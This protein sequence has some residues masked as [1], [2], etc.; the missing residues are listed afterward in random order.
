MNKNC[1]QR[2]WNKL[3]ANIF[4]W[5]PT[6]TTNVKQRSITDNKSW[7]YLQ[8]I[9]AQA[10]WLQGCGISRKIKLH[11]IFPKCSWLI[12]LWNVNFPTAISPIS[13]NSIKSQWSHV[14]R[15]VL[16]QIQSFNETQTCTRVFKRA[17]LHYAKAC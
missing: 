15:Q 9:C 6:S 14:L 5:R 13:Y 1:S 17:I 16:S 8:N 7:E 10:H 11:G 2:I 3:L 4:F 12:P